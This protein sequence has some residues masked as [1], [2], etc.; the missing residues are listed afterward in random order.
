LALNWVPKYTLGTRHFRPEKNQKGKWHIK[1]A[2][3]DYEEGEGWKMV[4]KGD[5]GERRLFR[6]V[7]VD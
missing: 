5:R 6:Q 4:P 1:I 3:N 7:E 2:H